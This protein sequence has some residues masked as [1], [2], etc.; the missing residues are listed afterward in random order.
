MC[1]AAPAATH[2]LFVLPLV[3]AV[4]LILSMT[5]IGEGATPKRQPL[6]ERGL[7]INQAA[8]ALVGYLPLP[9]PLKRTTPADTVIAGFHKNIDRYVGTQVSHIFFN[10][11]YQRTAYPSKVWESYWDVA[12]PETDTSGWPRLTWLVHETG[13]D[14]YQVC[15]DRCLEKGLSPWLSIR[16]NDTHY[17][18]DQTK[19]SRLWWDHPEW[20]LPRDPHNGF[21]F[22]VET[23]RKY[24]LALIQELLERYDSDGLELDWMRFPWHFKKGG[25]EEGRKRLTEF[26]RETRRMT[27]EAAARRGHP[28]GIAARIPAV[29]E[30]AIAMGMDGVTWV[31][32]G[33]VDILILASVWRPSDTDQPIEEWRERIGSAKKDFVLAAGTDLW[34]QSA[35]GGLLMMN[36][37]ESMRGFTV[38]MLDRGADQI[39]CFNHFHHNTFNRVYEMP[40]G[41]KVK[42][43]DYLDL[44]SQTAQLDTS[45]DKP[46]R[47]VV[48]WH[49]PTPRGVTSPKQ[50]P[51][52]VSREQSASFRI[53]TGPKPTSGCVVV[54]AGLD[55]LP[56]YG[57]VKLTARLNEVKCKPIDDLRRDGPFVPK[58]DRGTHVVKTVAE[59]APRVVQFDVPLEALRPGYNGVEISLPE[60][61]VQKVIWFEIY[62]VP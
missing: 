12:N 56:G 59:V 53:Y 1:T 21:D 4:T 19:M 61:E 17:H 35:P 41:R 18:D 48:T 45:I 62:M 27:E 14:L 3:A 24:Y 23:V 39:Y 2:L 57:R 25:E 46:R 11:N 9:S 32:E 8:D 22:N 44:L 54:R 38:A 52:T 50:L 37:I 36:N 15:I 34:I 33:L 13:V 51:A 16:M 42:K 30:Y 49:D 28:V 31:Q 20:H 10:T 40:D 6:R 26:M 55:D 5:G 7:I 58:G 47:H 29:P 60:G 43:N